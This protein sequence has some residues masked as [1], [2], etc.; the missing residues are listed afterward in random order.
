MKSVRD[1]GF[2]Q[3]AARVTFPVSAQL[4]GRGPHGAPVLAGWCVDGFSDQRVT[5][6]CR[7]VG[8]TLL[9]GG[10]EGDR[11][12]SAPILGCRPQGPY[13]LAGRCVDGFPAQRVTQRLLVAGRGPPGGLLR[14][15]SRSARHSAAQR[16]PA[17]RG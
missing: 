17:R 10:C 8:A 5:S 14:G 16:P 11:L 2:P 6:G 13:A 12:V 3:A 7:P 1:R 4:L 9:E 15:R